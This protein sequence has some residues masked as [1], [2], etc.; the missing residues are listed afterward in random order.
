[1]HSI[2]R[3]NWLMLWRQIA[4][5]AA[6]MLFVVIW[7]YGTAGALW[8]M[9][10]S[11]VLG[12]A[13]GMWWFWR[14]GLMSLMPGWIDL[15]RSLG[16][17]LRALPGQ[18][19]QYLN[20]RVDIFLLA[21]YTTSTQVGWYATAIFAAELI[22]Y[23]PN[24]VNV[25]LF[26]RISAEVDNQ[27]KRDIGSRIIRNTFFWSLLLAVALALLAEPLISYLYG[28][29]FL[30]SAHALRVLLLGMLAMVPGKLALNHL[31]GMGRPQYRS[32]A[33][34]LGVLLAVILDLIMIPR[35]Q[36]MGAAWACSLAYIM[37][38]VLALYWLK[39][40]AGLSLKRSLIIRPEDISQYHRL[41]WP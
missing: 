23:L 22:W 38:S 6:L 27:Q 29:R 39:R 30:P 35:W 2:G 21:A 9:N 31:A 12:A 24:G 8:A 40:I 3:F 4:R 28:Q 7:E 36:L 19:L 34:L 32:S 1:M 10:V 33:S 5:L 14:S 37:V 18:M 41:L 13:L 16:Y 25:V 11:L 17:G 26:P 20:Y 15:K